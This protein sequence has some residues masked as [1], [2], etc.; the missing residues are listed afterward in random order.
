MYCYLA[1]Y[2]E[3]THV[4]QMLRPQNDNAELGEAVQQLSGEDKEKK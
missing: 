2:A 4:F 1:D 3:V